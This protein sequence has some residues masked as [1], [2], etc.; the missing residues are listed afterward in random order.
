MSKTDL[1]III[2]IYNE[3]ENVIK[4]LKKF[5]NL[6]KTEF[7]VLLCYDSDNDDS[8]SICEIKVAVF[9]SWIRVLSLGTF[10]NP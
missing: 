6:V 10:K 4:L 9:P 8:D 1:E 7:K 3:G 5:E 2:P